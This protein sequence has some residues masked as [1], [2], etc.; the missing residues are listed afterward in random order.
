MN[1][2][3][4]DIQCL[5]R[6]SILQH[7]EDQAN[8]HKSMMWLRQIA[9]LS[10]TISQAQRATAFHYGKYSQLLMLIL[11]WEKNEGVDR[12]VVF[13]FLTSKR[14]FPSD[15]SPAAFFEVFTALSLAELASCISTS[16]IL[17]VLIG[18][19]MADE[20]MDST[21]AVLG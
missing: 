12:K 10:T 21:E 9:Q 18:C 8:V 4:L 11:M 15:P 5:C 3:L 14:F 19:K 20:L 1:L 2:G 16:A 13:T 17:E 6:V 7:V